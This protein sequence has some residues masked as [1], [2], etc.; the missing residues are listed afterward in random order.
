MMMTGVILRGCE[1]RRYLPLAAVLAVLGAVGCCPSI[2]AVVQMRDELCVPVEAKTPEKAAKIKLKREERARRNYGE[3]IEHFQQLHG[4][5]CWRAEA[6]TTMFEIDQRLGHEQSSPAYHRGLMELLKDECDNPKLKPRRGDSESRNALRAWSVHTLG[7]FPEKDLSVFL[8]EVLAAEVGSG[9]INWSVEFAAFNALVRRTAHVGANVNLRNKLLSLLVTFSLQIDRSAGVASQG[10]VQRMRNYV[11]YFESSLKTYD[12]VVDLLPMA[13]DRVPDDEVLAHLASSYQNLAVGRHREPGQE[14][15]FRRNVAKLLSLG[16]HAT[17][18]VRVRARIILAEFAPLDLFSHAESKLGLNAALLAEDCELLANLLPAADNA[19]KDDERYSS[20]RQ[21]AFRSVFARI[22]SLAVGSREVIYA[23][24]L[25]QDS[26]LLSRHLVEINER[27]LAESE[28]HILQQIRYLRQLRRKQPES[29]AVLAGAV[30]SFVRKRSLAVRKQVDAELLPKD[31]QVLAA[32]TV[33]VLQAILGEDAE[34]ARFV[35]AS[36]TACLETIEKTG[37]SA[38][39]GAK[40]FT[41]AQLHGF[42]AHALDRSEA[43][44]KQRVIA[45]LTPRDPNRLAEMLCEQAQRE[46]RNGGSVG[47]TGYAMLGDFAQR[48]N[49]NLKEETQAMVKAALLT[50]L[51]SSDEEQVLL[52]CRYLLELKGG[53]PPEY[54]AR[55]PESARALLHLS[56]APTPLNL[57]EEGEP[58]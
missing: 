29:D 32:A 24:L 43:D 44:V 21:E 23:R 34:Q 1:M 37:G 26:A 27:V 53:V 49:G 55:L 47:Q 5:A 54:A 22:G 31:A 58:Q 7:A 40:P 28:P 41:N 13:G 14:G 2:T 35:V 9:R 25:V 50:G 15:L 39:A 52:C 6:M 10:D 30:A 4:E 46:A 42:L 16:W 20:R 57:K 3:L 38:D 45:F 12:A 36:Y 56:V 48:P 19:G 11:R 17:D 8:V 33:P 51:R 18:A